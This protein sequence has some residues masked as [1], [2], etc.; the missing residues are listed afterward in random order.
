MRF[1]SLL[2]TII[3][4]ISCLA[5]AQVQPTPQIN[6]L[7]PNQ[8][9]T[10]IEDIVSQISASIIQRGPELL[11]DLE[12]M[13]KGASDLAAGNP[14]GITS[15]AKGLANAGK[16]VLPVITDAIEKAKK[17]GSV[18]ARDSEQEISQIKRR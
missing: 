6:N 3:L 10:A 12:L 7:T 4:P 11:A 18:S 5:A 16:M 1:S 15:L 17:I 8:A 2:A 9:I 14:F 13:V